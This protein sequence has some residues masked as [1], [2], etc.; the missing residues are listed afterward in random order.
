M[1]TLTLAML[2]LAVMSCDYQAPLDPDAVGASARVMGTVVLSGPEAPATTAVLIYPA[3]NPPP[4]IGT[5][6]PITFGLV[7]A[8]EFAVGAGG[9]YEAPFDL[10]LAGVADGAVLVTALVDVDGDFYPLPPFSDVTAGATCGDYS[11]AHVSDLQTGA[12]APVEIAADTTVDGVTVFVARESTLERPAFVMQGGSPVLVKSEV[13]TGATLTFRMAST[14]IAVGRPENDE[15]VPFLEV[16][17]P[18]DGTDACDTSFWVTVMD[19]DGDGQPDPHP[20]LGPAAMDVWPR[21]LLQY[22]GTLGDDGELIPTDPAV[23]GSWAAEAALFPDAVWFGQV[24]LNQPTP[25]TEVEYAWVPGAVHTLPDGSVETIAADPADPTTVPP[26]LDAIPSGVWSVT[27]I[28]VAGQT[29]TLPNDLPR[30]PALPTATNYEP[31]SQR[32]ALILE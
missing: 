1:R 22:L 11:G 16:S 27:L 17:G 14:E 2:S 24:P 23:D 13:L 9:S 28:N 32:G 20:V 4:P 18:F 29:W 7:G 31:Q 26:V 10:S 19:A 12:L 8:E 30:L 6:R 3:D 21:V 25:L 15:L 5:G